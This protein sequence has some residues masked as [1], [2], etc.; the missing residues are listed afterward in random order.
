MSVK[1]GIS[2]L[3]RG[4][5]QERKS[6]VITSFGLAARSAVYYEVGNFWP[7]KIKCHYRRNSAYGPCQFHTETQYSIFQHRLLP[8]LAIKSLIR[9]DHVIDH[10][11]TIGP[12]V[13]DAKRNVK[14]DQYLT[15]IDTNA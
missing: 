12:I 7:T 14:S 15:D 3:F 10:V 6:Y 1:T 5:T 4:A 8:P 2:A 11:T 9:H 13:C